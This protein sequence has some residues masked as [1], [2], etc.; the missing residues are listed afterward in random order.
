[1]ASQK[2]K[3]GLCSTPSHPVPRRLH[4]GSAVVVDVQVS[5]MHQQRAMTSVPQQAT[6]MLHQMLGLVGLEVEGILVHQNPNRP[7]SA[8]R[9]QG[10]QIFP[11]QIQNHPKSPKSILSSAYWTQDC[12]NPLCPRPRIYYGDRVLHVLHGEHRLQP[13]SASS[14][15]PAYG[16]TTGCIHCT[17]TI[18]YYYYHR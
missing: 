9:G 1:M 17:I 6:Q 8:K 18:G 12:W 13:D 7:R 14:T 2:L 5:L 10:T 3:P 16:E 15:V 11:T 4:P